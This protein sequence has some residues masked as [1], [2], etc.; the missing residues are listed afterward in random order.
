MSS[1]PKA[2][3]RNSLTANHPAVL[4]SS[5]L[6][7]DEAQDRQPPASGLHDRGSRRTCLVILVVIS[8]A[9]L[10]ISTFILRDVGYIYEEIFPHMRVLPQVMQKPGPTH[11]SSQPS[12]RVRHSFS[13]GGGLWRASGFSHPAE[14]ELGPDCSIVLSN[15]WPTF[16]VVCGGSVYPVLSE[17]Y[18]GQWLYY[19]SYA[20]QAV[21]G[22]S[23]RSIRLLAGLFGVLGI[24]LLFFVVR[25]E[26]DVTTG[27]VAAA[28]LASNIF[29]VA[30]FGLAFLFETVPSL[31]ALAAYAAL[32]CPR[33]RRGF[34][35]SS[36]S[37]IRA[38]TAFGP[39]LL[40]VFL[41]SL[42]VSLKGTVGI[43]LLPFGYLW[44]VWIRET[45]LTMPRLTAMAAAF[46]VPMLPFIVHEILCLVREVPESSLFSYLASRGDQ[47]S[48]IA[49]V[50]E[51]ILNSFLWL[52]VFGGNINGMSG[53]V[54]GVGALPWLRLDL[55]LLFLGG[56]LL[57]VVRWRKGRALPLQR[58]ALLCAAAAF[59]QS[60]LLYATSTEVQAYSYVLPFL[61]SL[62]AVLFVYIARL[63]AARMSRPAA[64]QVFLAALVA[65]WSVQL[66]EP[67]I[68]SLAPRALMASAEAD[69][70]IC[71]F[72][73]NRSD[74]TPVV[75]TNY[76]QIGLIEHCTGG[77]IRPLHA[78]F[79]L[80]PGS[81]GEGLVESLAASV[82]ILEDGYADAFYLLD[83]APLDVWEAREGSVLGGEEQLTGLRLEA[84]QAE[85]ARRGASFEPEF[86][87]RD[88][89]GRPVMG[90]Y[91]LR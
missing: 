81:T 86:E 44:Y 26:T 18:Q 10:C 60:V 71:D 52:F 19:V 5:G 56:V 79:L 75:T 64:G 49:R 90:L 7:F 41:L 91:R 42:A 54:F 25:R 39:L 24:W 63:V 51:M 50:P 4:P 72:L 61:V 35:G 47:L 89:R 53:P 23:L 55:A 37:T 68:D 62:M 45:G 2:P 17:T 12:P 88:R 80:S 20:W 67:A 85:A 40:S 31:L 16:S 70:A 78:Y 27:L 43:L 48:G 87:A 28:L 58:A 59:L 3:N 9:Y 84:F 66:C 13:N 33:L 34:G 15:Q 30:S 82:R 83:S 36:T 69:G 73:D 38:E 6:P 76:N 1:R 21:A 29:Y 46:L 32:Q 74:K 65:A 57:A 14:N 22:D 8:I 11:P 77:G